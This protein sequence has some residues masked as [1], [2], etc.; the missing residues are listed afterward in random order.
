M[1]NAHFRSTA[2]AA[3]LIGSSLL[4][5]ATV[6]AAEPIVIAHRG[7][8]GYLPEHTL[9]GYE[10]AVKLG[11]DYIEPDL[12]LTRDGALVAIHDD[13][14]QRTTNVAD[15]FGQRGGA[16]RVADFTLAEIKTLTVNP[17][18]TGSTTYPGFMPIS[19]ELRVPT[20]QEVIDVA[21]AQSLIAGRTIGI[22]PEAKQADPVMEDL[23][24]STLVANG[25]G[26]GTGNGI[27][28]VFIQSFSD[29]TIRSIDAKQTAMG[30]DLP[31]IV[32]GAAV[33]QPDNS[34]RLGVGSKS[35]TLA[36][37]ASFADGIGVVINSAAYP[38]T[39]SFIDQAHAAGLLVHGWTFSKKDPSVAAAE[40]QRYF[41]LGMDGVFSNYSDLAVASRDA[42]VASIPEPST[43]ALMALGLV[44]IVALK[45]RERG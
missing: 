36:E 31:L 26:S 4:A 28:K 23:I 6:H 19:P 12:Q 10:L 9:A 3:A 22:Y 45:R 24:L 29:A 35:L 14:L 34:A 30:L 20:F 32:L 43:Y 38:I 5:F 25:Y 39:K 41:A 8:S 18:G 44:G 21:K 42:F 40:Y 11:A 37:V 16:Y 17:T 15:L 27:Q 2:M 1:L 13:T 7:A 33:T